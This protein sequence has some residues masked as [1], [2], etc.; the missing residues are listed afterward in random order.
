MVESQAAR[1]FGKVGRVDGGIEV[2]LVP[3]KEFRRPGEPVVERLDAPGDVKDDV[4]GAAKRESSRRWEELVVCNGGECAEL[5]EDTDGS[6]S[7]SIEFENLVPDAVLLGTRK[8]TARKPIET[9][10]TKD[11]KN[12]ATGP[13]AETHTFR[14]DCR[15]KHLLAALLI[16]QNVE[17]W[18]LNDRV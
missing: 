11:S 9:V 4:N 6:R 8:R 14:V 18:K 5:A 17:A 13:H 3:L 2:M 7:R 1:Y 10:H 16:A 15:S 12:V